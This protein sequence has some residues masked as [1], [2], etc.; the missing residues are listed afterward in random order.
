MLLFTYNFLLDCALTCPLQLPFPR[1][2]SRKRVLLLTSSC[3][4]ISA[5]KDSLPLRTEAA[6][7]DLK[8]PALRRSTCSSPFHTPA[9]ERSRV[10]PVPEKALTLAQRTESSDAGTQ[11]HVIWSRECKSLSKTKRYSEVSHSSPDVPTCAFCTSQ[12]MG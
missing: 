8:G 7:Q 4:L 11:G 6:K 12:S 2:A 1:P 10:A 5:K 9:W 3:P